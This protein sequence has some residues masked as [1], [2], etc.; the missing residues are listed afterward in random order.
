VKLF[1]GVQGIR[2]SFPEPDID[3]LS[4]E[5]SGDLNSA[6]EM[7]KVSESREPSEMISGQD[8]PWHIFRIFLGMGCFSFGGPAA[9]LSY[10]HKEFV[11]K[12]KWLTEENYAQWIALSQFLPGPGSSQVGFGLGL[13]RGGLKG[14]LAAFAGFTLPSFLIMVLVSVM[15]ISYGG[16][17]VVTSVAQC[18][19]ILAVV[20]V[21]DATLGMWSKFCQD[22]WTQ[23]MA[24]ATGTALLSVSSI[25][26]Q[27]ICLGLG[28]VLGAM[29]HQQLMEEQTT[30]EPIRI[31]QYEKPSLLIFGGLWVL[32]ILLMYFFESALVFSGFYQAGSLVFGGGHVVLP[33][34]QQFVESAIH[35]DRFLMGYA[36]AQAIPGPMFSF[37]A[38]LGAELTPN[39]PVVGA[40]IAT[41]AIFAPGFLLVLSFVKR[42]K[43]MLGWSKVRG[44]AMGINA[45][46]VGI[47]MAAC[48]QPVFCHGI[49]KGWHMG[50]AILGFYAIK[51]LK[52]PLLF[53]V[54]SFM[55]LGVLLSFL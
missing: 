8:S 28:A 55:G 17:A 51:V 44:A 31:F 20:V 16:T 52:T 41:L 5:M 26:I 1:N 13:E 47:L 19:K 40:L 21:L 18:L 36:A 3:D 34:L 6:N 45:S 14:A 48:Y 38:F 7:P 4:F 15:S 30:S 2:S 37:G 11:E 10:F 43:Q 49:E 46:V 50:I 22:K 42:W 27:F 35:V 53:M 54:L 12:R 39:A 33:M 29:I 9:H 25:W 24:I 23:L 32:A